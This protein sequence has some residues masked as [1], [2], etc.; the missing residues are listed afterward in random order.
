MGLS[1]DWL[2]VSA[3]LE[4]TNAATRGPRYVESFMAK[5]SNNENNYMVVNQCLN[6]SP[7]HD[8]GGTDMLVN[9]NFHLHRRKIALLILHIFLEDQGVNIF[10]T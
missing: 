10:P 2:A 1:S 7:N 8:L 5:S 3:G 9:L 6:G 4:Y